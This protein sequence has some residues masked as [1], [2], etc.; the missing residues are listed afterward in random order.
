MLMRDFPRL[1]RTVLLL[2][3]TSLFADISTEMLYPILPLFLTLDLRASASIVGLI[4]GVAPATQYTVQGFS[5][6]FADRLGRYKPLAMLGYGI[7]AFAKPM[8]GLATVW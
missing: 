8:I 4:E 3:A 5:G 1:P 7:A 2:A 6:W